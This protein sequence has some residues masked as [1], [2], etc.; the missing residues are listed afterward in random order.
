MDILYSAYL[1]TNSSWSLVGRYTI[2]ELVKLGHRVKASSTNGWSETPAD[3][4]SLSSTS[5]QDPVF[6]GYTVPS[7]LQHVGP[8]T[9]FLIYNYE[10]SLLPAGWASIINKNA[11]LVLPA[12]NYCRDVMRASGVNADKIKVFP[13]GVDTGIFR[14]GLPPRI[15]K[16]KFNFLYCAIPHARK[17][18]DILFRAFL[19]EFRGVSD[20][21]LILK[22][23]RSYSKKNKPVFVINVRDML[24]EI[25]SKLGGD[26]FPE[27][28]IIDDDLDAAEVAGIY[29][30]AHAYVAPSRSEGFGMTLLEAMACG[31]P[32][33]ASAYSAH[34]DFINDTNAYMVGVSEVPAP[35]SMQYWQF[36]RG[37]LIGEPD[38]EQLA[39]QMRT[40]YSKDGK[41]I[42]RIN[43]GLKTAN[44]YTWAKSVKKLERHMLD[45][46]NASTSKSQSVIESARAVGRKRSVAVSPVSSSDLPIGRSEIRMRMSGGS[47]IRQSDTSVIMNAQMVKQSS[48]AA[49]AAV[50]PIAKPAARRQ[51]LQPA[52]GSIHSSSVGMP[53]DFKSGPLRKGHV[54]MFVCGRENAVIERAFHMA[55][56][57]GL[58]VTVYGTTRPSFVADID[59]FQQRSQIDFIKLLHR[60]HRGAIIVTDECSANVSL[61]MSTVLATDLCTKIFCAVSGLAAAA[62]RY[63][64]YPSVIMLYD[65]AKETFDS[66][67]VTRNVLCDIST[68]DN[69]FDKELLPGGILI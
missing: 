34:L 21:R 39:Y 15:P 32:V 28:M 38:I 1:G 64:R 6:L 67:V 16:D 52:R 51:S 9:R 58:K 26:N 44:E 60:R 62:E 12:S 36:Q 37:A 59:Q 29:N 68:G 69:I 8:K 2:R 57:S 49:A 53:H 13:Y 19:S 47:S 7:R 41:D 50:Q 40:L 54:M 48:A 27:V 35:I 31:V 25:K 11:S 17:G 10:S 66:T 24:A 33:I 20:A 5:L 3:V 61:F 4:F 42:D 30:S 56:E 55:S 46:V 65:G 23:N 14:T 63:A 18:I 43:A 22:T 45:F